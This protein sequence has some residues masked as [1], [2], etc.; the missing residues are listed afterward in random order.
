MLIAFRIQNFRSIGQSVELSLLPFERQTDR[1][2]N[3]LTSLAGQKALNMAA[4]YGANAAGK[5]NVVRAIG[6]MQFM[7]LHSFKFDS[8]ALLPWQ[9]F[10]LD[11]HLRD[12]PTECEVHFQKGEYRYRYGFSHT[13]RQIETEWLYRKSP[14]GREVELFTRDK[15]DIRLGNSYKNSHTERSIDFVHSNKL[16]LSVC[17]ALN[18]PVAKEVYQWF[19]QC[20][21]WDGSQTQKHGLFTVHKLLADEAAQKNIQKL[22]GSFDLGFSDLFARVQDIKRDRPKNLPNELKSLF[23]H[24]EATNTQHVELLTR[25]RVYDGL[26]GQPTDQTCE[27]SVSTHESAG[28][29][30]LIELSAP[31]AQIL[32]QGGVLVIDELDSRLHPLLTEKLVRLFAERGT[33][34]RGVQLI[35]TTHDANLL[36]TGLLRRDQIWFAEKKLT[37]QT[38]LTSLVEYRIRKD[39]ALQPNYL[40][41][42]YGGI[43]NPVFRQSD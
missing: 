37:E 29:Q 18:V 21:I 12:A 23:D 14:R 36:S 1:P 40:I 16:Y 28:T 39:E 22:L 2:E 31:I 5:S 38:H 42:R 24:L 17:D 25:H 4:I 19:T 33:N 7:V 26:T 10:L 27:F 43:P 6:H 35:F 32:E 3:I 13:A 30:K 34:P 11:T 9:P 20:S 8:E 15:N 41:G